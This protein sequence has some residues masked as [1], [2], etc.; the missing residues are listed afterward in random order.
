MLK[1]ETPGGAREILL[2]A[3]CAPCSGA[4]LECLRDNGIRP[5]VFFSNSNITPRAEYDLRLA[6]LR[7]Y[8]G[9]MGVELVADEYD[10]DA[11]LD[12]VRGLEDEPERGG[13]CAACFRFRLGRAAR[14]A[15]ARGLPVLATTLASSRWKDLDQV[16]AAGEIA[17]SRSGELPPETSG[18]FSAGA[19]IAGRQNFASLIPPTASQ[20]VPPVHEATGGHGFSDLNTSPRAVTTAVLFWP[21][22]WRKGG[23]QERRNEVIRE[24]GFYNQTWCGCEFSRK[25]NL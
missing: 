5:V 21:Q 20:R 22:N 15:A 1:V 3:C 16:N 12:A 23:L 13:R 7:R 14:Y 6:E 4:I 19:G 10:H 8:A 2:H 9:V 11:W 25:P 24:Q 17:C 18:C